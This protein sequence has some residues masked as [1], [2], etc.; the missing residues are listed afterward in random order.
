MNRHQLRRYLLLS[1]LT[2]CLA[3]L[4]ACQTTEQPVVVEEPAAV[5]E[6]MTEGDALEPEVIEADEAAIVETDEQADAANLT[7]ENE[8]A[9]ITPAGAGVAGRQGRLLAATTLL[10]RNFENRDG[11]VSG[12]IENML[13][14]L[15]DGRV[16]FVTLEYGGFLNIGDKELP[17][18]LNA[19]QWGAEDELILNFDEARLD[20]LPDL[21]GDWPDLTN[22]AWD[23]DIV[24]FWRETG[25]DPGFAFENTTSII[26]RASNIMDLAV[27]DV[28]LGAGEVEDLLIDLDQSRIKYVILTYAPLLGDEVIAVP[29]SAFN[30]QVFQGELSFGANLDPNLLSDAPRFSADSVQADPFDPALDEETQA[31][32]QGHGVA[33]EGAE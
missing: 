18:P 6:P 23:D 31:Y 17:V 33:V 16:L 21:G 10:D 14:D 2:L 1:L 15:T 5:E 30:T 27:G 24:Q 4:V 9:V 29:F 3:A 12:E 26:M 11:A 20:A 28:G 8:I 13:I 25:F 22:A 7:E 19:L 32:W